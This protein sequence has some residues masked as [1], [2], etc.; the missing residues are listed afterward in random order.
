MK[1]P[2]ISRKAALALL[3]EHYAAK[4]ALRQA[5]DALHALTHTPD[6]DRDAWNAAYAAVERAEKAE[7]SAV[8][9]L[10]GTLQFY[11]EYRR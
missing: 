4:A 2:P 6:Y 5:L 9:G 1:K 7:Q 8:Y 3:A 10:I 11:A